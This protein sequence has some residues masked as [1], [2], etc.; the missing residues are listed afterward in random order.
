M[1]SLFTNVTRPP[2]ATVTS[3]GETAVALIVT[4]AL[5]GGGGGDVGAG[6]GVDTDGD[7]DG[8]DGVEAVEPQVAV[9]SPIP[10][11]VESRFRVQ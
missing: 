1:T 8:A 5:G 11:R 7:G 2:T 10:T 4:V 3:A 9:S 6:A